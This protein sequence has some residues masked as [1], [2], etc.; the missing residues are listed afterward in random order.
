MDISAVCLCMY[1]NTHSP[2]W[3]TKVYLQPPHC[4]NDSNNGLNGV[5]VDNSFVLFTFF[6][7]ITSFMDNPMEEKK[8]INSLFKLKNISLSQY[9]TTLTS[10][11]SQLCFSPIHQLLKNKCV[12]IQ[13]YTFTI[14]WKY[15]LIL[16]FMYLTNINTFDRQKNVL[17]TDF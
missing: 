1:F 11:A 16:H 3:I 5:T 8:K 10:F 14:L 17:Q 13:H 4:S 15:I 6:F 2:D 9:F 7:W 12:K